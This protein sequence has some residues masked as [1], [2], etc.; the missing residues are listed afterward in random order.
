MAQFRLAARPGLTRSNS[1]VRTVVAPNLD[2]RIVQ[3]A[4]PP[5]PQARAVVPAVLPQPVSIRPYPPIVPPAPQAPAQVDIIRRTIVNAK[6]STLEK[7]RNDEFNDTSKD[8]VLGLRGVGKGRILVIVACG[9]SIKEAA[10][11]RL[12]N[13]E[14]IDIMSVN[15]P[16]QRLH[17]TQY[18]IFCDHT[19]YQRNVDLFNT[20][21]GHLINAWTIGVKH[22]NQTLIRV[23]QGR[24]FSKNLCLGFHIGRSTTYAAMQVAYWMGYEKVFIFGC[25]MGSVN[26]Q[27]HF[28][29]KNPDVEDG[30]R[31]HRFKA[32]AEH[33]SYG[34][35]LLTPEERQRYVFCSSYNKFTF[36][37]LFKRLDQKEAVNSILNL[38]STMR[39]QNG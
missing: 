2:V 34:A 10:L 7:A 19:Q 16:D 21:A 17:P 26:G 38:A 32:E 4:P 29:G 28:Y 25:D 3:Q 24:G 9:P 22:P 31:I 5:Q 13:V 33:F 36:I 12:S 20:Y 39:G 11:E 18:W 1:H 27:L 15:K 6:Q 30:V 14:P 35:Q 37:E 8:K 23:L